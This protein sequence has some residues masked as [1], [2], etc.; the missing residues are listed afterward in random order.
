M[1]LLP[2]LPFSIV[3]LEKVSATQVLKKMVFYTV[4]GAMR[5][6]MGLAKDF[7]KPESKNLKD[8]QVLLGNLQTVDVNLAEDDNC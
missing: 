4:M 2:T 7:S 1:L 3:P 8:S 5:E 6:P